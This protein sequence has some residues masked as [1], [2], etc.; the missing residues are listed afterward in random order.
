MRPIVPYQRHEAYW[1]YLQSTP[2]HQTTNE[3][4]SFR[5]ILFYSLQSGVVVGI[6]VDIFWQR[7]QWTTRP[8]CGTLTGMK[9]YLGFHNFKNNLAACQTIF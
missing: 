8:K 6:H 3:V 2:K 4:S 5:L 9:K 1:S 7:H